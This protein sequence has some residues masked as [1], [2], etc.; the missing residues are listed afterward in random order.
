MPLSCVLF[1]AWLGIVGFK[2]FIVF[3]SYFLPH[4]FS[5]SNWQ[6]HVRTSTDVALFK[7]V[8]L[9]Q[10]L[11]IKALAQR[12]ADKTGKKS[13]GRFNIGSLTKRHPAN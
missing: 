11:L 6:P 5:P 4:E 8:E 1:S 7:T 9:C 2:K 10:Y 3:N 12:L 13:I